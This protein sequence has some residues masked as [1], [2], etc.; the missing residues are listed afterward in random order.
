MDQAKLLQLCERVGLPL[1]AEEL[2]AIL[3]AVERAAAKAGGGMLSTPRAVSL[4]GALAIAGMGP[5]SSGRV[6]DTYTI[7]GSVA[8]G[9]EP[10]RAGFEKNFRDGLERDAQLCI[11]WRGEAVVDLWGSNT[12]A[13]LD[14]EPHS[15]GGGAY[16]GDTIQTVYSSTKVA[17]ATVFA[18][19]ADRG[20]LRYD[21]LVSKHWPEFGCNGKDL[22]IG[23]KV[24]FVLPLQKHFMYGESLCNGRGARK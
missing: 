14:G 1:S 24:I 7:G 8:P 15:T 4:D 2:A 3:P 20:H 23:G 5:Y 11:Y 12:A 10:V 6:S 18:L 13:G 9:F 19:A 17:A 21:D 22:A 16:D